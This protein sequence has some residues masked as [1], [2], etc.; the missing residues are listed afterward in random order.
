MREEGGEPDQL[1]STK[2]FKEKGVNS[3]YA[4]EAG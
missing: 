3:V 4:A 1:E 2:C